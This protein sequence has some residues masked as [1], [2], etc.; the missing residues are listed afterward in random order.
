ML[1]KMQE[2]ISDYCLDTLD[3]YDRIETIYKYIT[4]QVTYEYAADDTRYRYTAYGA[5]HDGKAVCQGY[6]NLLYRML[7]ESGID[8]RLIPGT[9][10]GVNHAWNIVYIDGLYY[11]MDV[12]HDAE[13]KNSKWQH[14][15]KGLNDWTDHVAKSEYMSE[16]FLMQYNISKEAYSIRNG[17]Y[18]INQNN[19]FYSDGEKLTGWQKIEDETYYFFRGNANRGKMASGFNK[20]DGVIYYFKSWGEKNGSIFSGWLKKDNLIYYMD[21]NGEMVTG[22][23][24]ISGNTYYFGSGGNMYMGFADIDQKKY[25][26]SM[27]TYRKGVR[28]TGLTQIGE[29]YYYFNPAGYTG[30]KKIGQSIWKFEEGKCIGK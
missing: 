24:N 10:Y 28:L 9:Y 6:A 5:L 3:V 15:L 2:I 11:E 7:R 16:D 22:W 30:D 21:H 14:F 19:Y 27:A 20:I 17:W 13:G 18:N 29:D 26:F 1:Q 23:Q 12:T 8:C 4:S 25:Y